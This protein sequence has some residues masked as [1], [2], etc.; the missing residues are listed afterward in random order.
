VCRT[1]FNLA[2]NL[3]YKGSLSNI[4]IINF[5]RVKQIMSKIKIEFEMNNAAFEDFPEVEV[6]RILKK[7][8]KKFE[9]SFPQ[10]KYDFAILD[11][12]GNKIGNVFVNNN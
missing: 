6:S 7:I 4:S 10:K 1:I 12:N 2:S 3:R 5:R 11:I 8:D 9:Y